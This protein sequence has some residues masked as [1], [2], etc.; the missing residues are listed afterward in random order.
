MKK[1]AKMLTMIASCMIVIG[2][3]LATIGVA[4][5]A[6]FAIT[7]TKDGFK[8][9][10]SEDT[11][12]EEFSLTAFTKIDTNL[13]DIDIE[14]IPSNEYKLQIK[15]PKDMEI[16][17]KVDNHELS[18]EEV[19]QKD[20][21]KFFVNLTLTSLPHTVIR[22]YV[23]KDVP[24]ENITLNNKFGDIDMDE[25]SS[26]K[27]SI[28][29]NDGDITFNKVKTNELTIVSQFGDITGNDVS[30]KELSIDTKDGD[31]ILD[32]IDANSTLINNQFG[33][34][35]FRNF[36]SEGLSIKSNDGDL[37]FHGLLLGS[38]EIHSNFGDIEVQLL[39]KES[40]INYNIESNFGDITVNQNEYEKKAAHNVN[41]SNHLIIKAKDGD[42]DV[43]F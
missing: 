3:V 17:H 43:N 21:A 6:K 32:T 20:K 24:F 18:I 26:E 29:S 23:P 27:I 19:E 13:N 30:A 9:L 8:V 16:K 15:R 38:S 11:I 36:T 40:E 4:S 37:Q 5:G 12:S 10:S 2:I 41:S 35:T 7:N 22:I 31:V 39:N 33:D 25:I 42:V 34:M 28:D 14:I 1:H